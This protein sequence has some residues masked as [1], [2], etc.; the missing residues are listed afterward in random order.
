[1]DEKTNEMWMK[2]GMFLAYQSMVRV[3]LRVAAESGPG[4]AP[5]LLDLAEESQRLS[6]STY[7]DVA[8]AVRLRD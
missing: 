4:E 2:M 6:S 8:R 5:K 3:A 7:E 1:M